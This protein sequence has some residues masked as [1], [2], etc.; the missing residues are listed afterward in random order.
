[1]EDKPSAIAVKYFLNNFPVPMLTESVEPTTEL[2]KLALRYFTDLI[3]V[4]AV[5]DRVI[6]Y[7]K[8]FQDF[9][10]P[11]ESGISESEAIEYHLRSYIQDF[12]ILQERIRKI[13]QNLSS[14]LPKYG[15]VAEQVAPALK[16]LSDQ[17][18]KNLKDIT[19][20]LRGEHVHRRSI[21][22]MDLIAGKFLNS[23]ITGDMPVPPEMLPP[24]E[25]ILAR[26][27]E[28]VTAAK[29]KHQRQSRGNSE[30][31]REM[32]EWFAARFIFIF[33]NLN[34]HDIEGLKL[35]QF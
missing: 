1:M 32:K 29:E 17:V 11:K 19:N 24:K 18:F 12:Y 9:F 15:L 5:F 30:N 22:E 26:H 14:D 7:E 20:G 28:V 3:E 10:P 21:S 35:E 2:E 27:N 6:R 33:S 23:L 16:H 34:G 13:T 31:L 25:N 4:F 8:Y